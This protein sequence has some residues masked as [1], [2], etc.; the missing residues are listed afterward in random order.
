[1]NVPYWRTSRT[2]IKKGKLTKTKKG[3][4]ISIFYNN[5]LYLFITRHNEVCDNNRRLTAEISFY[6]NLHISQAGRVTGTAT[7]EDKI[8]QKLTSMR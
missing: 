1:M 8:L 3:N 4:N 5:K 6:F 2:N 7:L